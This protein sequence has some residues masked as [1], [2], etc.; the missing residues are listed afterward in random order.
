MSQRFREILNFE[1]IHVES[2][3][4]RKP[5]SHVFGDCIYSVSVQ[6]MMRLN[7]ETCFIF[8]TVR[9]GETKSNFLRLV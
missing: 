4:I 7:F 6:I 3:H 8:F 5:F 1:V 2:H 9:L